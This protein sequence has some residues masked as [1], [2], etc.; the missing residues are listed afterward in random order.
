MLCDIVNCVYV[1]SIVKKVNTVIRIITCCPQV[2]LTKGDSPNISEGDIIQGG[3]CFSILAKNK[4]VQFKH[5]KMVWASF[6]MLS[7]DEH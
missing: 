5:R 4:V 1:V 3:Q 7:I 2:V 6:D